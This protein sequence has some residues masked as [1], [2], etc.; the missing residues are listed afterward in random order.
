MAAP[1]M[2]SGGSNLQTGEPATAD[3][4]LKARAS[5]L[6][7]PGIRAGQRLPQA[8]QRDRDADRAAAVNAGADR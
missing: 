5:A 1:T 8:F 3:A 7:N 2:T 4:P 6:V